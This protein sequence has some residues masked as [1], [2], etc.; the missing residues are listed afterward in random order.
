MTPRAAAHLLLRPDVIENSASFHAQLRREAPV[1]EVGSSGVFLVASAALVD[2][3]LE[4]TEELSS[5]LTGLLVTEPDGEPG[6]FDMSGVGD[7]TAALATADDPEH[8]AH[9]RVVQPALAARRVAALEPW[10]RERAR[11]RTRTFVQRGGDYVAAVAD[12]L[13]SEVVSHLLGL[14]RADRARIQ[15]WAMQGGAMLAGVITRAQLRAL[16]RVAAEHAA[17]LAQHF[18]RARSDAALR[19]GAPLLDALARGV[20]RGE[21]QER[22]ALGIAVILVGAGGES[23]AA[24]I[25]S[26]ARLLAERP[27]LQEELRAKPERVP[28][29]LEEAIRL[30]PPFKFHYRHVV[31]TLELGGVALPAGS[32]AALLWASANRDEAIYERPD[33]LDLTRPHPRD[34]SSFGRGVHF[35]VGAALAR[36]EARV[37]LEELL[38]A[39]RSFALDPG[40]PARHVPSIFVRRL[41][42][43]SLR[44]EASA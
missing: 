38:A 4:R 28:S 30:E 20:E 18:A 40:A 41:A 22:T 43:L 23:T 39:T 10:L 29:F 8:A 1:V 27:A 12:P 32:R 31:R 11:E 5:H 35:C 16:A 42:Q 21:L 9:R 3:A 19:A 33:E 44:V 37:A 25:G 7:S 34:H 24:W 15:R 14:P 2:E 36:L 26:A 6:L 13:P 17:Y